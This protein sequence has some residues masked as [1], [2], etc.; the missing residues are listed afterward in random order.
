VLKS[1]IPAG[2]IVFSGVG[3][4]EEEITQGVD[5]GILAFNAESEREIGAD[6]GR[7]R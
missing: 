7:A 1:G 3:K 5:A 4:T 6:I 2:R